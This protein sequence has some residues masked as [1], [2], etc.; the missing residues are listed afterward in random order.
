MKA[1]DDYY[2]Y[3]EDN[4][5]TGVS[6][7]GVSVA[8]TL[9]HSSV[10]QS[11]C[12]SCNWAGVRHF[13]GAN[14]NDDLYLECCESTGALVAI[15]ARDGVDQQAHKPGNPSLGVPCRWDGERRAVA[16]NHQHDFLFICSGGLLVEMRF[17]PDPVVSLV[18]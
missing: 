14:Q 9:L 3:C 6:A 13:A 12:L 17:I 5:M 8:D 10:Q 18:V 4:Y 16:W 15:S 1:R 7:T 2:F 11:G